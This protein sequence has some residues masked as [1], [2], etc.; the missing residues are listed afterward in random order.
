MDRIVISHG[1]RD[2]LQKKQTVRRACLFCPNSGSINNG[3]TSSMT[4]EGRAAAECTKP[5]LEHLTGDPAIRAF[6]TG[7]KLKGSTFTMSMR[8]VE[9]GPTAIILFSLRFD[10]PLFD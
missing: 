2:P 7:S 3:L 1:D 6:Q 9:W 4:S 10:S 5:E 8:L